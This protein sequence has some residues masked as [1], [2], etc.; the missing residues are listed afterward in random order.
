MSYNAAVAVATAST[1]DSTMVDDATALR[2]T[3]ESTADWVSSTE[4]VRALCLYFFMGLLIGVP[5]TGLVAWGLG[6]P[7][8]AFFMT[9][10]T[11]LML[12]VGWLLVGVA[13][14]VGA[15][16]D[17]TCVEAGKQVYGETNELAELV[18]CGNSSASLETYNQVW[19]TLDAAQAQLGATSVL[20]TSYGF[21]TNTYSVAAAELNSAN[22][23]RNRALL[24]GMYSSYGVLEQDCTSLSDPTKTVLCYVPGMSA[25]NY[26]DQCATGGTNV[27]SAACAQQSQILSAAGMTGAGYLIGCQ[28]LDTLALELN[29]QIC[30]ETVRAGWLVSLM[31]DV[32]GWSGAS[33]CGSVARW[34]IVP[35][36]PSCWVYGAEPV[37]SGLLQQ[38]PPFRRGSRFVIGQ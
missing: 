35:G 7:R 21:S 26:S 23:S 36:A 4:G 5:A 34:R 1:I 16:L 25:L 38:G 17:D 37:R 32:G 9:Q 28:H 12:F 10:L 6:S 24:Q 13:F 2:D 30:D 11:F 29:N 31:E 8:V 33:H 18:E 22:Y 14:A 20:E 15:L 3:I 27:N 19:Q